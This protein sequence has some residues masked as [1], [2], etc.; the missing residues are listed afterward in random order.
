MQSHPPM[1]LPLLHK[2]RFRRVSHWKRLASAAQS[3]AGPLG[4]VLLPAVAG[5]AAALFAIADDGLL[6]FELGCHCL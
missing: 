3:D 5:L 1:V 2:D 4:L 6:G